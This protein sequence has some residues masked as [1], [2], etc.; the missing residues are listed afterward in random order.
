M[1]GKPTDTKRY[2]VYI[3][4]QCYELEGEMCHNPQC[5]FCRRT[6]E[7]VGE[8]LDALLIR[9]VIDGERLRLG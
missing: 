5:V 4:N 2:C 7:E 9:P 1:T 6:M 8:F 3:C